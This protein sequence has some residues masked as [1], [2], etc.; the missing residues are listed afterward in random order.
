MSDIAILFRE[1]DLLLVSNRLQ[2]N[3]YCVL[4]CRDHDN[5]LYTI[6]KLIKKKD[7]IFP[8]FGTLSQWKCREWVACE[9]QIW[10]LV[11]NKD[12]PECGRICSKCKTGP[13]ISVILS[14]LMNLRTS[15]ITRYLSSSS[16]CQICAIPRLSSLEI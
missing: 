15:V 1:K 7:Y 10:I 8:L 2:D 3:S 13:S 9:C 14:F 12:E 16:K 11:L 6:R 5:L 4:R